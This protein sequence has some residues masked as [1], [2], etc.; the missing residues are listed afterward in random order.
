MTRR[1]HIPP[2][3]LLCLLTT[4]LSLSACVEAFNSCCRCRCARQPPLPSLTALSSTSPGKV[5]QTRR[6]RRRKSFRRPKRVKNPE[7]LETWRL[8]G[9]GV[10]PDDLSSYLVVGRQKRGSVSPRPAERTYLTKPVLEALLA[11]LRIK[12]FEVVESKSDDV[13]AFPPELKDVRIVRRSV[14]ARR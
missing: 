5:T 7:T 8:F 11:R 2:P 4:L 13:E 14:D 9:V 6:K 1:H 12:A 3:L 10:H